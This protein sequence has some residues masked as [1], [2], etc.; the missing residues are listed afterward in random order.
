[1]SREEDGTQVHRHVRGFDLQ[2]GGSGCRGL[3]ARSVS[4]EVLLVRRG[5]MGL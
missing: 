1:M 4:L 2:T 5:A 3:G